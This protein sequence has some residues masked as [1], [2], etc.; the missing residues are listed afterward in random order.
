MDIPTQIPD[1]SSLSHKQKDALIIQLF[2]IVKEL[3]KEVAELKEKLSKNSSNSSKPP[4]SDQFKKKNRSLR[5]KSGK[6]AGGQKGRKGCY[7]KMVEKPDAVEI[8]KVEKCS[9]CSQDIAGISAT[10]YEKGQVFD[11]PKPKFIVTEHQA[12]IKN[13]PHCGEKNKAAL[14][15]GVY[16]GAQYGNNIKAQAVYLNQYQLLPYARIQEYFQDI[17]GQD[18]ST[19]VLFQANENCY[20]G[21]EY[22]E[23]TISNQL[24]TA[25]LLN[26]DETSLRV[27]GGLKWLHVYSTEKLTIYGLHQKRGQI[28]MEDIGV[29]PNYIGS[30]MHDHWKPYF[31]YINFK[32]A[33]CNSH[34]LRELK[35]IIEQYD[36]NWA[37]RMTICLLTIKSAVEK[38]KDKG[39]VFLP[40][41]LINQ[42]EQRYQLIIKLGLNENPL[43]EQ[44]PVKKGRM[45]KSKAR[46]LVER[47]KDYQAETLAFMYD[48]KIP[49]DNNQ[50]ERDLRM[51]KVK[52]KISGL[53]RS[54]LGA[55]MFC[56]IRG[57]ISTA[58]KHKLHVLDSISKVFEDAPYSFNPT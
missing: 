48:F 37:K 16:A 53:F 3:Q 45:K 12:E 21:L 34:H 1:L 11:I 8:H 7:L 31:K 56:R 41:W 18:I 38:Y 6:K 58:K 4:S 15:E 23:T 52:Q 46:N 17:F 35:F 42:Y 27:S 57:Y 26:T 13:C 19:G 30:V 47:L 40:Q 33:L 5:K 51:T 20:Y 36:Q 9:N 24:I 10:A 44:Q 25:P 49:F 2:S 50:A 14:P 39:S 32:H 55:K 29:L 54:E 22:A 43:P 28:A